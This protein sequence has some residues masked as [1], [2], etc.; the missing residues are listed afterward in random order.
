MPTEEQRAAESGRAGRVAAG[1]KD[2]QKKRDFIARQGKDETEERQGK[3]AAGLEKIA[4][5]T[6]L[7]QGRQALGGESGD[8]TRS[9][10]SY[11]DGGVVK[12]TGPAMLHKGERVVPAS[13]AGKAMTKPKEK[14]SVTIEPTRPEDSDIAPPQ[15]GAVG[16]KPPA[17]PN[18]NE[19]KQTL[20]A[21]AGGA[22][23]PSMKKGGKVEKTGGY[24]LHKG[25]EVVPA[26][27][28]KKG[29]KPHEIHVRKAKSGGFHIEHRYKADKKA[30]GSMGPTQE[31]DEHVVGDMAGLQ[32]H[33]EEHLGGEGEA[34]AQEG[35]AV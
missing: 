5:E 1:I 26:K 7:E 28:K 22:G 23:L 25:E 2:P 4:A 24:K 13:K 9:L 11:K 8:S 19:P 33:L 30:D 12:K 35:M 14:T 34:P 17:N 6:T 18:P 10:R 3:P 15:K 32:S 20:L 21:S 27:S 31:P 16:A 29:K